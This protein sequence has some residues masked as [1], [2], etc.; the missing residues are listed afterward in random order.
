MKDGILQA[1][2][3]RRSFYQLNKES[4]LTE[5]ELI[6][7][8]EDIVRLVPDAYDMKSQRVVL[9][10][11]EQHDRLW[12]AIYNVFGGKV[13]REKIDSF[14]AGVGTVLFFYDQETIERMQWDIPGG[15]DNFPLWA[16]QSNGMLQ[17]TMWTALC[18]QG[19]GA[20]LQHYNPV[21][22]ARVRELFDV[23]ENYVLLAQLVFGGI[24]AHPE[25]KAEED[26]SARVK[27]AR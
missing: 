1:L 24:E 27:I 26:I 4:V 8:V 13:A 3:T 9:A 2:R 25:P 14:K 6:R 12:D 21:I 23:P 11:G 16:L 10:F 7:Y 5:D 22:D 15:A 17:M 18:E 20:S 19:Y